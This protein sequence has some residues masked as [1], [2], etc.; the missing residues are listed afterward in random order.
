MSVTSMIFLFCF[1]PVALFLYYIAPDKAKEYVLLA[2]S[3]VFYALGS[4]E[5]VL[6]F[7]IATVITVILGRI[8][9]RVSKKPVR[10]ILLVA[11]IL[12]NVS[13]LGYYKY[14]DTVLL[15]LGI[16]FF[17]FK[18]ISYLV[19]V[20]T[21]KAE[22]SKNPLHDA[23]YL[24]FFA[25]IQSGP[26]SRYNE[27]KPDYTKERFGLFA[28]GAM[29]FIIGFGKKVLIANILSNVTNEIFTSPK[30]SFSTAYIWLGSI[31][32]SLQLFLDFAGYSDMAIGISEMFG[33]RCRENFDY[34]YMTE[35]VSGFWRRWHISLSE[36]FRDYVYI[37]LGGSRNRNKYRVYINLLAV[38]LLT[39]IWHGT[40]LNF[41]AWGLGYFV[42]I[43]FEKMTGFPK[44]LPNRFL[45]AV[46][47]ILTLL[48][49]NFEWVLF[50]AQN[51]KSGLIII[52]EM[53]LFHR[54][55]IAD[56]R[57]LFLIKDNAFFI[58]AAL[59]LCF[60]LVPFAEKKLE[61]KKALRVAFEIVTGLIALFGFAWAVSF[62]VAGQ[63]NPF[64]YANF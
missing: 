34:P 38:W 12:V 63:N 30:E 57:T 64:L 43:S 41:I 31:C 55:E 58:A 39:G 50:K 56:A 17:T 1:L 52:R 27:M 48:F 6:L 8:I 42:L 35:S 60:P 54:N 61:N 59:V 19:D 51:L 33:Y 23:L 37:P 62:V 45:K 13:L 22:L 5:F 3:L 29:R 11:G 44:K 10:I 18:A 53:I 49:I 40:S 36:W 25:Q 32:F 14:F 20:F 46:Y 47:R 16:S 7:V 26:L 24:S 28:D 2:L 9:D 4:L 21:K 15:P